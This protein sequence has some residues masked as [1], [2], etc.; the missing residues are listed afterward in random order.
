M[1]LTSFDVIPRAPRGFKFV[2]MRPVLHTRF[3]EMLILKKTPD[4]RDWFCRYCAIRRNEGKFTIT[5]SMN[6]EDGVDC[7]G[8]SKAK[9]H[10]QGTAASASVLF[11]QIGP[12]NEA[13]LTC[14]LLIKEIVVPGGVYHQAS[15]RCFPQN[16]GW[17][18]FVHHAHER[19]LT[20]CSDKTYPP[21]YKNALCKVFKTCV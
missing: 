3:Y 19:L 5:A 14:L 7:K 11:D 20:A 12:T 21:T 9:V 2:L 4:R 16:M 17:D 6:Y 15:K 18:A 10:L 8:S 13:L 1:P